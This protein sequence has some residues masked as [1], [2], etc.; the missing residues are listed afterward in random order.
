[1]KSPFLQ[2]RRLTRRQ[3]STSPGQIVSSGRGKARL[4][5]RRPRGDPPDGQPAGLGDHAETDD[6]VHGEHAE[7]HLREGQRG[8]LRK[9]V[10][11]D[12]VVA[13]TSQLRAVRTI[14][15]REENGGEH[16]E[17]V[18]PQVREGEEQRRGAEVHAGAERVRDP[19]ELVGGHQS[20][21]GDVRRERGEDGAR[22]HVLGVEQQ[23]VRHVLDLRSQLR[24]TRT[25]LR[26]WKS[27]LSS[28]S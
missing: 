19:G 3:S 9:H 2:L 16:V 27:P 13:Y 20:V 26:F 23:D 18:R 5:V 10:R 4:R 15:L 24:A 14:V 11:Q 1:M 25:C 12:R 7:K 8:R 6:A 22:G 17:E 28:T 21:L